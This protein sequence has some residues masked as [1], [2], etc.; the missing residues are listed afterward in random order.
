MWIPLICKYWL[1]LLSGAM[2]VLLVLYI[3]YLKI[4]I[5]DT[6]STMLQYKT[7][8]EYQNTS[9]LQQKKEYDEKLS[10]LPTEIEKI[11][12]RYEVIYA[13]IDDWEGDMNATDAENTDK[14]LR[15]I[16]Y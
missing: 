13:N 1:Q 15:S 9:L 6:T 4:E 14:F 8:L 7:A 10:K 2:F 11:K 16:I 3:S 5:A 12:V